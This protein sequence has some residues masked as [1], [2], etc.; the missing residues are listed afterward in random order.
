MKYVIFT[1]TGE[2]LAIAEKL[3]R[4]HQ[5][6]TVAMIQNRK[7]TMLPDEME[8][9]SDEEPDE[10]KERMAL[11]DGVFK[12]YPAEKVVAMLKKV[13]DKSEYFLFF[14]FNHAFKYADQLKGMGFN[15]NFPTAEDRKCEV[16]RDYAKDIVN[17]NYPDVRVAEKREFK[18][19]DDFMNEIDDMFENSLWVLK[20]FSDEAK[21]KVPDSTDPESAKEEIVSAIEENREGYEKEGFELERYIPNAIEVTPQ[22]I[23]Y[24]GKPIYTSVDI[25][26]KRLGSAKGPMNGCASDLV[27]PVDSGSR[28]ARIAF[29]KYVDELAKQHEGMFVWD[30]SLLI[31]PRDGTI[32]MGEFCPNRVG[33]NA[34]YTELSLLPFVSDFFEDI[35]AGKNPMNGAKAFGAS[36]RLFFVREKGI[37]PDV[38]IGVDEERSDNLWLIDAKVEKDGTTS[39]VG[40]IWDVGVAT[41]SGFSPEE[42]IYNCY[43]NADGLVFENRAYGRSKADFLSFEE[44]D[45]ILM[46]Y[47]YLKENKFI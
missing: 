3:Q 12:K 35:V 41:G 14:D 30:I 10:K 11:Y 7:D 19:V 32:Y 47:N 31:D 5:S 22:R 27:F 33:Y 16:D 4:E 24:N 25:E 17:E 43:Y 9:F 46:R 20:P 13:K 15:G 28:I 39:T 44:P 6:V 29:P 36:V 42:A 37:K 26:T 8:S 40:F 21:T 18:S 38:R 34:F 23:Y 1:H 2:G 45:S